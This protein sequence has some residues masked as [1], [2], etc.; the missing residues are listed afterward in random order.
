MGGKLGRLGELSDHD[1][2]QTLSGGERGAWLGS[3]PDHAAV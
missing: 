3:V 2:N 1:L